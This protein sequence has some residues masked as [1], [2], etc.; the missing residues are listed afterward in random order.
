MGRGGTSLLYRGINEI[1]L[2]R[3]VHKQQVDSLVAT[4]LKLFTPKL[5]L[6]CWGSF[7]YKMFAIGLNCFLSFKP[8]QISVRESAKLRALRAHLPMCL[9]YLRAHVPASLA[10]LR[11]HAPTCLA[12]LHAHMPMCLA[13]LHAHMPMCLA[14]LHARVLCVLTC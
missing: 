3:E 12:C 1:G 7:S 2:H 8:N 6:K 5:Y 13:C 14:C 11:A 4:R 9:A 10:C